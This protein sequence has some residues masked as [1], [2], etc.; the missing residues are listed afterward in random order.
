MKCKCTSRNTIGIL[1]LG[2]GQLYVIL[3]L[4]FHFP[5]YFFGRALLVKP[6]SVIMKHFVNVVY[7]MKTK[8]NNDTDIDERSEKYRTSFFIMFHGIYKAE[9]YVLEFAEQRLTVFKI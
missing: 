6:Y 3:G 1:D 5:P 7:E 8:E 9:L 4:V 2:C